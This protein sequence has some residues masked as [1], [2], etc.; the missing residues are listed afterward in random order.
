MNHGKVFKDLRVQAGKN[1]PQMAMELGMT[2]SALWKIER[3]KSAPKQATIDAF[4]K[5]IH[6]PPAFYYHLAITIEDYICP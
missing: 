1:R 6:I 3:G 4:C 5:A 2:T